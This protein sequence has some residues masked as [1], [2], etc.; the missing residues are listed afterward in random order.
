MTQHETKISVNGRFFVV[1]N[2]NL[3][4]R[5]RRFRNTNR[6]KYAGRFCHGGAVTG[7]WTFSI[8]NVTV[9]EIEDN[10]TVL[11]QFET[12]E[13]V[14]EIVDNGTDYSVKPIV[15]IDFEGA[16]FNGSITGSAEFEIE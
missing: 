16:D 14:V 8:A 1:A 3:L 9:G 12:G 11:D 15:T 13:L 10:V 6:R 7:E 5:W 4:W 2:F